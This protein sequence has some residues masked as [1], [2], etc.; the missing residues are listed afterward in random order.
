RYNAD[1]EI[2]RL[3]LDAGAEKVII[4]TQAT[5]EFL[6]Q[7]P[8]DR[9]IA[10]VDAEDGEVVVEGWRTK[11]GADLLD[12]IRELQPYVVGFLVTFVEREGGM[13]GVDFERVKA[14]LEAAG[15]RKVTIAGGVTSAAEIAELDCLGADA[16]VGMAIYSGALDLTHAFAAPLRS[17][18]PDGLWPTIVCDISGEA[19]GLAYSNGVSLKEAIDTGRGVYFSRSRQAIWRKGES[20]GATQQLLRVDLDCDRDAIRFIVRQNGAGFCHLN[21]TTCWGEGVGELARLQR[22][23]AERCESAPAGSYTHRL[24]ND[25]NLLASKIRE[26]AAELADADT[27]EHV[28]EEAAD[29]IY[30]SLVRM[31]EAGVQLED[32]ERVLAGRARRVTRRPGNAK[33][34]Q[35]ENKEEEAK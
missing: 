27:A 24:V 12:R 19:L 2:A 20:S 1:P 11:S 22:T 30:F 8:R 31:I 33:A 26:E 25:V 9:V 15:G 14:V 18:R 23:I 4:G 5:P 6:S 7:L 17:D 10:A 34:P 21:S 32:V 3:L 13:T 28:A 29:V 35:I 16:Q